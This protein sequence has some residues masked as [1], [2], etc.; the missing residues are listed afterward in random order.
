MN[1]KNFKDK[2]KAFFKISNKSDNP[3]TS[4]EQ[5]DSDNKV[6]NKEAD[7]NVKYKSRNAISSVKKNTPV[8]IVEI[9]IIRKLIIIL[10]MI[11][12][13]FSTMLIDTFPYKTRS[14]DD[15]FFERLEVIL[16]NYMKDKPSEQSVAV[17]IILPNACVSND[18]IN[19]PTM[20]RGQMSSSLEVALNSSYKNKKD[21]IIRTQNLLSNKQ[22]NTYYILSIKKSLLAR[23]FTSLANCK[24]Y[25]KY[26]SYMANTTLSGVFTLKPKYK[27]HTFL[28]MDIKQDVTYFSFSVKGKTIAHYYLQFGYKILESQKLVY[29]NMIIDH[30]LAEIT[31]LNAKE[32]AKSKQLTVVSDEEEDKEVD[33]N[34][35]DSAVAQGKVL[36][37]K[38][39]KKLPKFMQREYENTE[40]GILFENFRIFM[41]WALLTIETYN[42][43]NPSLKPEVIYVNMPAQYNFIL[44][45]VNEELSENGILFQPFNVDLNI[46]SSLVENIELYGSLFMNNHNKDQVF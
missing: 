27:N 46:P 2:L 31:V 26:A 11:G 19:I 8:L 39:P 22:Y 32:K 1:S 17:Y 44:D 29:E 36:G 28:F 43:K 45:K 25:A 42:K 30:T 5:S 38:V 41:K 24:M 18:L 16:N 3:N 40:E 35:Q 37:K 15:E 7:E 20:K 33:A 9:D 14:L 13:D 34:N 12:F 21:L 6:N 4:N 23:F 10:S